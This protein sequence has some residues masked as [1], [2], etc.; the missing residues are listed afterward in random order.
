M[1]SQFIGHHIQSQSNVSALNGRDMPYA[2][3]TK[4]SVFFFLPV[5]ILQYVAFS[6]KP[7]VPE[8]SPEGLREHRVACP[9]PEGSAHHSLLVGAKHQPRGSHQELPQTLLVPR[10]H[11]SEATTKARSACRGSEAGAKARA[12]QSKAEQAKAK[13]P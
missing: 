4:L 5:I 13:Q 6:L 10:R 11:Q 1:T 7:Q 3:Q 12:G 2:Q 8:V 9:W